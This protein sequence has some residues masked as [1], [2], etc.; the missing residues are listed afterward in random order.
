VVLQLLTLLTGL[1]S[2]VRTVDQY[3]SHRNHSKAEYL[4]LIWSK[5]LTTNQCFVILQEEADHTHR[6]RQ[7]GRRHSFEMFMALALFYLRDSPKY[8][9]IA[10]K[11]ILIYK[12]MA[13]FP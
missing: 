10:G 9:E 4:L 1:H 3:G 12:I 2:I 6:H 11:I 8:L 5:F 13:F 7:A